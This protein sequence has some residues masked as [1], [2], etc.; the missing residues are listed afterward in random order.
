M[1]KQSDIKSTYMTLPNRD[2]I[3]YEPPMQEKFI[4]NIVRQIPS[5]R[6][7]LIPNNGDSETEIAN[8]KEK[9]S[10]GKINIYSI[11]HL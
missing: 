8:N 2:D 9:I 5:Y 3:S 7:H 4:I 1:A 11:L 6:T 10:T